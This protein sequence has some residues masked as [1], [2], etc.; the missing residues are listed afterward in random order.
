MTSMCHNIPNDYNTNAIMVM[1]VLPYTHVGDNCRVVSPK[2][3]YHR[4][5]IYVQCMCCVV[6]CKSSGDNARDLRG[7]P[8][9]EG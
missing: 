7:H 8:V 4:S 2:V 3:P 9:D 1:T 5:V 6:N